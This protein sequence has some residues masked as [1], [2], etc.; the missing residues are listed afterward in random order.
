MQLHGGNG[1]SEEYG[2]KTHRDAHDD[3]RPLRVSCV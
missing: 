1:Y 2:L 3:Q